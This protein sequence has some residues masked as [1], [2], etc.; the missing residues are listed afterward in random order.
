[1]TLRMRACSFHRLARRQRG[2]GLEATGKQSI[3]ML[4]NTGGALGKSYA[5]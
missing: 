1:L 3:D 5:L 4:E 2:G